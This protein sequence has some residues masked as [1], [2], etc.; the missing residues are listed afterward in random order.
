MMVRDESSMSE[1]MGDFLGEWRLEL[2]A[3]DEFWS[4]IG[5]L[6]PFQARLVREVFAQAIRDAFTAGSGEPPM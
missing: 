2:E 4:L 1:W 3:A 5:G 6:S